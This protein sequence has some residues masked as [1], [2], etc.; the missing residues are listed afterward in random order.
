MFLRGW[1]LH[2]HKIEKARENYNKFGSSLD[3]W[4]EAVA[5]ARKYNEEKMLNKGATAKTA[6]RVLYID[7]Q[8]NLIHQVNIAIAR[9]IHSYWNTPTFG[10]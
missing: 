9:R 4:R 5:S 7:K 6:A 3:E 10:Y 1:K 2:Y 8:S